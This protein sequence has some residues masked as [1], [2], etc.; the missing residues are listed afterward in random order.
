[1]HVHLFSVKAKL[2]RLAFPLALLTAAAVG[3]EDARQLVARHVPWALTAECALAVFATVE[4]AVRELL[5]RLCGETHRCRIDGCRFRIRLT[6]PNAVQS[7][8][9]QE[10]AAAH[11]TH[12]L[13]H[14]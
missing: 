3:S 14:H 6:C 13:H 10:I 11:P 2:R 9:W 4:V 12:R 1:M 7:R 8:R 5:L